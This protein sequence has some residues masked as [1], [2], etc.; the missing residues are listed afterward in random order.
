VGGAGTSEATGGTGGVSGNGG[1]AGSAGSA[2]GGASGS[3]DAGAAGTAGAAG[4]T[5]QPD[6]MSM[7]FFVTSSG[8]GDGGNLG[9]LDGADA[10]CTSLATAAEPAL[11]AKTWRAYLSTDMVD[12]RDRIG[13]GPWRNANLEI[14]ANSVDELHA[15][16]AGEALDAT[17]PPADLS[18]ALD[19][20]GEEVVNDVH[21]VLTGSLVDG[22]VATGLTC[23]NWTSNSA[24]ASAQV[25]H[26]NRDGGGRPPYFN[27]THEVGC[28]EGEQNRESGTVT[29]GG[30]RGSIYCFASD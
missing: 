10:F 4:A 23:D 19:E 28:A 12:A 2:T 14:V 25:G 30:G 24:D 5:A 21:D 22:T 27:A 9:G 8:L 17:W 26:S 3:A 6:D 11:A 20:N 7:S 18:V 13:S 15:Q 29:Q 1:A 16:E